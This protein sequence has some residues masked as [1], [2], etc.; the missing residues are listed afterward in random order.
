MLA[1]KKQSIID[2]EQYA[3]DGRLTEQSDGKIFDYRNMLK[4]VKEM[5]RPLTKQ[6]A[7]RYRIK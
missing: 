7:E 5:G 6:E 1:P 3:K 4:V 2:L